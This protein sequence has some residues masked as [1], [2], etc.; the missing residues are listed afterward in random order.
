MAAFQLGRPCPW[1]ATS[2][3]L[4]GEFLPA[5]CSPMSVCAISRPRKR[6]ATLTRLPSD[7]N[8]WA[9]LD[10]GVEIID[11]DAGRHTDFL[12]LH[13]PLVFLG[14]L[15]PLGLLETVLAVVHE[16]ADGRGRRWE[17]FSPGP[18]RRRRP[19]ARA[20]ASGG[21]DAQLFALGGDEADLL[22]ADFLVD[23]MS[24]VS[25]D[26]NAPPVLK[27][28]IK[29]GYQQKGIRMT[30]LPTPNFF[31]CQRTGDIGCR[32]QTVLTQSAGHRG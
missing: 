16:L 20:S 27:K 2:A 10:L 13:D 32:D 21:H 1:S 4:G 9:L 29:N 8:F 5:G 22:V 26:G 19:S 24:R 7:R 3:Q 25:Y 31:S 11:V 23:L 18:G 15:L 17:R 12:D 6:T 30:D 14:L 28:A